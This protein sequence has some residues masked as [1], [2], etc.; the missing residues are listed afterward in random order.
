MALYDLSATTHTWY[1]FKFNLVVVGDINARGARYSMVD[2]HCTFAETVTAP[3]GSALVWCYGNNTLVV[4]AMVT[5]G[6]TSVTM[7]VS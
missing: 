1:T 2:V 6:A 3:A 7:E 5:P 4:I